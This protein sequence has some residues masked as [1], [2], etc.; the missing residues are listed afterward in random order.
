MGTRI[1]RFSLSYDKY[2]GSLTS[3]GFD[4]TYQPFRHFGIGVGYRGLFIK[5]AVDEERAT[6]RMRQTF[7]GPLI[8]LNTSFYVSAPQA[9]SAAAPARPESPPGTAR[10]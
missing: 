6:L 1:D 7:Q 8:F 10:G 9:A 2:D 3:L 4:L 5:M